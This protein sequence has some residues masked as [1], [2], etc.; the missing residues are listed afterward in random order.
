MINRFLLLAGSA[1]TMGPL[2]LYAGGFSAEHSQKKKKKGP[3]DWCET[4]QDFGTLYDVKKKNN[5]YVQKVKIFGRY[6]QQ[7]AYSDGSIG[8][9]ILVAMAKNCVDFG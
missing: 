1:L 5:P 4:L 6:Q 3:G 9:V 7:W 2:A 8:G